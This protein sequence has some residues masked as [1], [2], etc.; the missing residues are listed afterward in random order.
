VQAL[1]KMVLESRLQ[2]EDNGNVLMV[3]MREATDP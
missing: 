3:D 1:L 2:L